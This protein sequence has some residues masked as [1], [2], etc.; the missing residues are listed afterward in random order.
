MKLSMLWISSYT[1]K[2]MSTRPMPNF[3]YTPANLLCTN[4]LMLRF[5]F[6]FCFL[7]L[8]GGGTFEASIDYISFRFII[9]VTL[10]KE[11]KIKNLL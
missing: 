8:G 11:P 10:V 5:Y 9:F 2:N 6:F 4:T 3:Y 1:D 7:V